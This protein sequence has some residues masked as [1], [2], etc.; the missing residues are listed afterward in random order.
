MR[1]ALI[2]NSAAAARIIAA[3]LQKEFHG[4]EVDIILNQADFDRFFRNPK[5]DLFVMEYRLKWVSGIELV[6]KIKSRLPSTPV[7][8][9]SDTEADEVAIEGMKMGLGQYTSKTNLNLLPVVVRESLRKAQLEKEHRSAIE[10]LKMSERRLE[11]MSEISSDYAFDYAVRD[12]GT[13]V[14]EWV[15]DSFKVVTQFEPDEVKVVDGLPAIIYPGDSDIA[16]DLRKRIKNGKHISGE[17]RIVTKNGVV[18]WLRYFAR[19]IL[20]D[21]KNVIRIY[22]GAKDVT[23]IK[24]FERGLTFFSRDKEL[25]HPGQGIKEDDFQKAKAIADI[26]GKMISILKIKIADFK[27]IKDVFGSELSDALITKVSKRLTSALRNEDLM[28]KR[29]EDEFEIVLTMLSKAN[30]AELISKKIIAKLSRTYRMNNAEINIDCHIGIGFYPKDGDS[31]EIL[32][33]KADIA[34]RR[35]KNSGVSSFIRFVPE[36]ETITKDEYDLES[37][38]K[39]VVERGELFIVYQPIVDL[40]SERITGVEALLRWSHPTNGIML[41][42][43]FIP[44]AEKTS[45]II[46]IGKWVL[47]KTCEQLKRWQE[48]GFND[49]I[50]SVN[51]SARQFMSGRIAEI[52]RE[53]LNRNKLDPQCLEVEITETGLMDN[54]EDTIISLNQIK[55]LNVKVAIDDFGTGYS[56]LAYLNFFPIDHLKIDRSF[57]RGL[58]KKK[59][60]FNIVKG[61]ITLAHSLRLSVIAEGVEE[62]SQLKILKSLGCDLIQGYF[63]WRPLGERQMTEILLY[64]K[65]KAS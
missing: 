55:R 47:E 17:F 61:V 21:K 23:G 39:K 32:S 5:Y 62:E 45:Q 58:S 56:S 42:R 13:V 46:P 50:M 35:A 65:K 14:N 60:A 54:I 8:M 2:E 34:R 59:D 1:F 27:I 40:N 33:R 30:D 49:L 52:L 53:N 36:M 3:H 29:N 9:A 10:N 48:M 44:F 4:L 43:E 16:S 41:P 28:A 25:V 63:Y 26:A 12:D 18:K 15:T 51:V 7:I 22:G 11:A 31:L 24:Q 37:R 64:R 38:L 6:K 57:I 20:D 19:P